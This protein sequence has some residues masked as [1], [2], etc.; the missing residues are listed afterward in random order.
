[1]ILNELLSPTPPGYRTEKD[2]H[3]TLDITDVRKRRQLSLTLEK[4]NRLRAMNDARKL[5]HEKK[6][7][8]VADQYRAPEAAPGL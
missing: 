6:L 7:E 8:K 2:D 5:E 3:S 1:M 4:L